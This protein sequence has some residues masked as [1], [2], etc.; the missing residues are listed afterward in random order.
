M[1]K[2]QDP[3]RCRGHSS[4]STD[5]VVVVTASSES[6]SAESNPQSRAEHGIPSASSLIR[7][8]RAD[9]VA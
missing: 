7:G 4:R 6:E 8:L 5:G 1:C 9:H 2:P 3:F